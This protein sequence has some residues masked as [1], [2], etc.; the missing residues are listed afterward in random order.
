M[1]KGPVPGHTFAIKVDRPSLRGPT[2]V[3]VV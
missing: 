3:V 2:H 1:E